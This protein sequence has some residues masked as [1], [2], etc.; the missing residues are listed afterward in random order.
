MA[1]TRRRREPGGD[2]AGQLQRLLEDRVGRPV[3][4]LATDRL[5]QRG[6]DD[7]ATEPAL[8]HD[9]VAILERA[10]HRDDELGTVDVAHRVMHGQHTGRAHHDRSPARTR[11]LRSRTPPRCC[12]WLR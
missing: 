8:G 5:A 12:R 7:L 11:A 1:G 10:R 9:V 6:F 3:G 2:F 4:E